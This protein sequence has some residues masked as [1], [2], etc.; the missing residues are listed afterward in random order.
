MGKY[1]NVLDNKVT[2]NIIVVVAVV[3]IAN[4]L[5]NNFFTGNVYWDSV[6]ATITILGIAYLFF[7]YLNK[8][9]EDKRSNDLISIIFLLKESKIKYKTKL[10]LPR[11]LV[12]RLEIQ[13]ILSAFQKNMS[14]RY[15]IKYL[16]TEE[17]LNNIF[18]IQTTNKSELIIEVTQKEFDGNMED[19]NSKKDFSGFDIS[20]ME[21]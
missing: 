10:K 1:L 19:D 6:N 7:N 9:K 13:G 5:L 14:E 8:L 17:Y 2:F 21:A 4:F 12:S 16:S 20:K 11:R 18:E 3:F 15:S